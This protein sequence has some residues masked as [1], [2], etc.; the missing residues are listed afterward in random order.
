MTLNLYLDDDDGVFEPN[1]DDTLEASVTTD[2][3]VSDF[4]TFSNID[5]PERTGSRSSRP[6]NPSTAG[7]SPPT[8]PMSIPTSWWVWT[9]TSTY[10]VNFGYQN[11][12]AGTGSIGD[13]V[14]DDT[15]GNGVVDAGELGLDNI[16]VALT[17]TGADLTCGTGDEGPIATQSTIDGSYDFTAL[18]AA[19]Y[20][21]EVDEADPDLPSGYV[22]TTAGVYTVDLADGQDYNDA[23]FGFRNPASGSIGDLVWRDDNA[24]GVQDGGEP[25]IVGVSVALNEGT[26]AAPGAPVGGS[27]LVTSSGGGY[28]YAG[29]AEGSYCVNVDETSAPVNGWALTTGNDPL[30]VTLTAGQALLTADFGFEPPVDATTV[31]AGQIFQDWDA[32]GVRGTSA[33]G[34]EDW[35]NGLTVNL[36]LDDGDGVFE[37]GAEDGAPVGSA[38]TSGNGDYTFNNLPVRT[39]WIDVDDASV[40]TGYTLST[41]NEPQLIA[42]AYQTTVTAAQIGFAPDQ[43]NISGQVLNN[44][45]STGIDGVTVEMWRDLTGDGPSADDI[46]IATTATAGGGNYS[47][48]FGGPDDNY[49]VSVDETTLP[50]PPGGWT[51][52][53]GDTNPAALALT[54]GQT[55]TGVDFAYDPPVVNSISGVVWDDANGDGIVDAGET[56]R[57]ANVTVTLN[58]VDT[59]C[60]TVV[61]TVGTETTAAD[62]AFAFTLLSDDEYC[63]AVNEGDVPLTHRTNRTT[64]ADN[65]QLYSV[66]GGTDVTDANFG[67]QATGAGAISGVVWLDLNDDGVLD[68]GEVNLAGVQIDLYLDDGDGVFEPG[69]DD[70]APLTTA[71]AGD[72]TYSFSGLPDGDYFFDPTPPTGYVSTTAPA[73][74][75]TLSG[76]AAITDADF[77]FRPDGAATIGDLVWND[78]NGNAVFEPGDG[79]TGFAGVQVHLYQDNNG[80]GA[81]DGGDTLLN[82]QTTDASG[83]YAFPTL[84]DG[85]YIVDIEDGDVAGFTLSGPSSD[86]QAV[87]I[88]GGASNLDV[89]FGYTQAFTIGDFVWNDANDN[90]VFDP[91]EGETG[92][93]G[94][95][96]NLYL[97][98]GDGL[99]DFGAPGGDDVLQDTTATS[100]GGQYIFTAQPGSYWVQV[101]ETTLP[102]P[103]PTYVRLSP[104][105]Y[106]GVT[107]TDTDNLNADFRYRAA[108]EI[109]GNIWY[110]EDGEGDPDEFPLSGIGVDLYQDDG[111]DTFEPG[112][113]DT[114]VASDFSDANGQ[115]FFFDLAP[116]TYWVDVDDAAVP[117]AFVLAVGTDPLAVTVASGEVFDQANFGYDFTTGGSSI[118]DLV[119]QDFNGDGVQNG[120]DSGVT[121]EVGLSLYYDANDNNTFEPGTGDFLVDTT[122]TDATGVYSFTGLPAGTYFV[123][124]DE[125]DADLISAGASLTTDNP[126]GPVTIGDPESFTDADFGFQFGA[127]TG[128]I[129]DLVFEDLNGD[130]ALSLGE[131]GLNIATVNLY[132]SDG[133]ADFESGGDDT[134]LDSLSPNLDGTYEFTNLPGRRLLGARR[135]HVRHR[136]RTHHQRRQ[137]HRREPADERRHLPAGGLRLQAAH[138]HRQHQRARMGGPQR[139]RPAARHRRDRPLWRG[140]VPLV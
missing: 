124:V 9:G 67:Y 21:V 105:A 113:D 102:T 62:G 26:C 101:D 126:Y 120:A 103:P 2:T 41:A 134:L 90:S 18:T 55:A 93:D 132:A 119:F 115:F 7:T 5:G 127:A 123:E 74:P 43:I 104:E 34:L 71:S 13:T 1:T 70:G 6:A 130:G 99:P 4:F 76:G 63:V 32:N 52:A 45:T 27:P 109:S 47:F 50:T 40:P 80:D 86:P 69:A 82:T 131:P 19:T 16:T 97:D 112:A 108:S 22:L 91:G 51:I 84:L 95:T 48:T 44:S 65:P 81:L 31:I 38:T 39:Y 100:G 106:I 133:D 73:A 72:G 140:R 96:L 121:F 14:W 78:D 87:T 107:I 122:T 59:D 66:A 85:D 114:L 58:R 20:C 49:Y 57:F 25:G 61:E 88:S 111:D 79:E 89:D 125:A 30:D 29:L 116:G 3:F 35:F 11:P 128:R 15:N 98:G 60:A 77:G 23:D 64:P 42:A 135:S 12:D 94:V 17:D 138:R 28:L 117:P 8:L 137:P 24:N 68:A 36:Y 83:N 129:G 46:Q 92:I 75:L 139:Q 53:A 54:V 136:L 10:D 118:G 33:A 110:D 37:P 56:A